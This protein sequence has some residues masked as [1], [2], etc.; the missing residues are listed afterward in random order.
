M[1][2]SPICARLWRVADSADSVPRALGH[3][4]VALQD[5]Y[6]RVARQVGLTAPQAELLCAA[7]QPAAVG[8]LA[9]TLRCDRTNITHLV[10][11]AAARRWVDRVVDEQDRRS[12]LITL[13]PE[14][15]RLAREFISRLE[16]QLQ[17][18]LQTWP[19]HRQRT[20][21][22]LLHDLAHELDRARPSPEEQQSTSAA[23][24]YS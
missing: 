12:T 1:I 15:E 4:R 6:L 17:P 13:T 7:L 10:E 5:S 16:A 11:R 23:D 18:L 21:A 14:G 8:R 9:E 20:T 2:L 24:S 22:A 19:D 3:L